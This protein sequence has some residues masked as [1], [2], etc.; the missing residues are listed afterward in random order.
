MVHR[1]CTL[2]LLTRP[3]HDWPLLIAA[4]RDEML[5]RPWQPPAAHWPDQPGVMGGLD[6]LAGGTWLAVNQAGVVA[7]V[8]NRTNALGPEAGRKSRGAL[9]LLA[10]RHASA[11]QAAAALATL[12]AGAYR[13]FNLVIADAHGAHFLRGL[14]EGSVTATAL[15]LGLHMVTSHDPDDLDHPR[16]SRHLPKFALAPV[17][18]PPDWS[19]WPTLL[20]DSGGPVQAALNVPPT[21]GFG[22][23]SSTLLAVGPT[24][25]F[26]FAPGPPDRVGFER[27]AWGEEGGGLCPLDPH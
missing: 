10:M 6:T 13:P 27:V 26:L 5:D 14:G 17:P 21:R 9:P 19:T 24:R 11:A 16:V 22:T 23:A 3:G 8:L 1:V 15:A 7:G 4:N 20:A 25:Q 12:D 18:Q 2:I